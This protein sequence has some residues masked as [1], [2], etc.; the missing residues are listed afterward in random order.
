[1]TAKTVA[2]SR[3][4]TSGSLHRDIW[5]LAVPMILEMGVLNVWQ[6]LDTLW[7][8]RLGTAALAAVTISASIRWV[9]NSIANGL[10]SGGMAVVARRV[11]GREDE[12]AAHAAWQTIL[13][14]T[15][16]S[17]VLSLLGLAVAR[18]ALL[19]LGADATVL[20]LGLVYMRITMCGMF[21]LVLTFVINS[22]LRGAGEASWAMIVL[23]VAT[24]V[25]VLTE[26]ILVFGWGPI[27]A[28]G[29]AGSA[30]G[31]VLGFGT[32]V[33]LQM[34]I[35]LSGRVRIH[36]TLR[37]L[38]PDFALMSRILRISLPSMVQLFLRTS[39]SLVILG[40]VGF[41]GTYATAGY[42]VANRMLML[43]II[44]AFGLSNSA[45]T[46]V[47]QNL[48]AQKPG[49][50]EQNAWWVSLYTGIYAVIAGMLLWT[51]AG[52]VIGVFDPT[53][54]V[55]DYGAQCLRV[56]APSLFLYAVGTVLGRAFV[57][58]GDP[59]PPMVVN[60]LSL[61]LIAVPFAFGL[62]RWL[63]M[64]TDGIFWGLAMAYVANGI[65]LILWFRRGRWKLREV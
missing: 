32:A 25:T 24:A 18:P 56:M 33:V 36:L 10:G 38:R 8:G 17:L 3:D 14:G 9:I 31:G 64:G 58:A 28:L 41:Y 4:L 37:G 34:V 2:P 26:W 5:Y 52:S 35:L 21:T 63:G 60:L 55:V 7:I 48:G 51:A 13:L 11:G 12:A 65:L 40:L 44:P 16:I 49:R 6:I 20:P 59:V 43:V 47:G 30:W 42:G 39:S 54:S 46:L 61:W 22:I 27:P 53:P 23:F 57:G 19:L 45:G 50:A 62:S 1:M 15:A 29:I